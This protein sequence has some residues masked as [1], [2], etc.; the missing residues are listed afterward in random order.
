VVVLART[1]ALGLN[2]ALVL[3]AL[4][5]GWRIV[6]AGGLRSLAR[7]VVSVLRWQA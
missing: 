1:H 5:I 6:A 2:G 3:V 4:V 7:D